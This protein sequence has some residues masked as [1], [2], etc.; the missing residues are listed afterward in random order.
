MAIDEVS[1]WIAP[2]PGDSLFY[3]NTEVSFVPVKKLPTGVSLKELRLGEIFFDIHS[4]W[5]SQCLLK[6]WRLAQLVQSLSISLSSWNLT[7]AAMVARA[8]VETASAFYFE[9]NSLIE[10]WESLKGN[11]VQTDSDALK[12]RHQLYNES[13]QF[14][15]A[16]R[17]PAIE[18]MSPELKRKNVVTFVEKAGKKLGREN[19]KEE[20]DVLCDAVHPS[21]GASEC[22]WIESGQAIDLPQ[23]LRVLLS[24]EAI[25]QIDVKDIN[26]IRPGSSLTGVI[27]PSGTWAIDTLTTSLKKFDRLCKDLCLTAHIYRFHNLHYWG[28]VHPTSN[29]EPC[30]CGSGRKTR[31]CRHE[32]GDPR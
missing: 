11:P 27:F 16:S 32:F 25:G 13:R 8:L 2:L 28:I 21:W 4:I 20:Y 10:Q 17:I 3:V 7:T 30:A 31:F 22:F 12:I 14:A 18:K 15:W 19:L 5:T 1:S 9:C 24:F 26:P 6:S 23:Q 29:Y